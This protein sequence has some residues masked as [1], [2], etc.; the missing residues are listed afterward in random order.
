[1][2]LLLMVQ[3][4]IFKLISYM[5]KIYYFSYLLYYEYSYGYVNQI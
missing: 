4:K 1:M 5:K 2:K 3:G